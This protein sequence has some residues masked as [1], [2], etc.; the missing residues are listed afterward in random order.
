VLEL[1]GRTAGAVQATNEALDRYRRKGN[2]T[3]TAM[4]EA[5]LA[6]LGASP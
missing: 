5:R 4:A 6:R 3:Q 2:V 1:A